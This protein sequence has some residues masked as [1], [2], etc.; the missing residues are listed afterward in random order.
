VLATA[1]IITGVAFL[2]WGSLGLRVAGGGVH[3]DRVPGADVG[4][5]VLAA[6]AAEAWSRIGARFMVRDT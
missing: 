3:P 2:L 5:L 4:A 6:S 1:N